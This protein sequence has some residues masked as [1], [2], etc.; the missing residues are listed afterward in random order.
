MYVTIL[1]FLIGER[2]HEEQLHTYSTWLFVMVG[3]PSTGD[4]NIGGQASPLHSPIK[5]FIPPL[6]SKSFIHISKKLYRSF[7]RGY[8]NTYLAIGSNFSVMFA[9]SKPLR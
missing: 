5:P 8:M 2:K 7:D 9:L 1:N 4:V 3:I 6:Q